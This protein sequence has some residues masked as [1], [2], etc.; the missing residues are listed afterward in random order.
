VLCAK[1]EHLNVWARNECK[2]CGAH[3]FITC[4]DCGQRNERVRTR[5]SNCERK[6][7]H[8][9]FDRMS[10]KA[11]KGAFRLNSLQVLIFCLGVA[12]AFAV[13][14]LFSRLEIPGLF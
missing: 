5:C 11:F 7:H 12:L 4:T 10:R 2:R 3:L 8:S 13:I 6:L 14:M 9:L 1:C